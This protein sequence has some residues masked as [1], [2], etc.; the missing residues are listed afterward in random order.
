MNI[1]KF[2]EKY[3]LSR[4]DLAS[5]IGVSYMTIFR[6]ETTPP[7]RPHKIIQEK[8]SQIVKEFEKAK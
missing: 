6:W 5:K 1:K 8:L 2:R 4:E 7:K 3:S